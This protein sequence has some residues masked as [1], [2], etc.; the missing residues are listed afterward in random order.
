MRQADTPPAAYDLSGPAGAPVVVLVHGLGLNRAVWQWM[1]PA[2]N[3]RFRV[4]RYDLLGHG[5]SP[6]PAGQPTLRDLSGQLA[7]LLDHLHIAR[8]AVVGFSLG[9][10]V[11]RRFAQDHPGRVRALG[12]LHTAHRRSASAQAA[13]QLRVAQA[14]AQGPAATVEQA[15]ERWYTDAC[16]R[17]RA[18]LMDLTRA[19]VLAND[20]GV[21]PRLYRIL[22]DGVDEL[23]AP[24]P[25]ISCPALVL[26]AD[27]DHGNGLEM[28]A[29]IA[30][31]IPGARLVILKGLRHM[32]LAEDPGAV[33]RPVAE[34]LAEVME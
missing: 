19:W 11:A 26:T 9:G 6:P 10:M 2:L 30:A 29:A 1:V 8:A 25:P 15:L 24:N 12:L 34:F 27:E 32:A 28:S 17:T 7:A 4:L 16:R 21:Y 23:V 5:E 31:E 18:D 33:N 14:E 22:A 13:I 3:Q 20:P